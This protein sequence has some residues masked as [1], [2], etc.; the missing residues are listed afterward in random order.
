MEE[1][2]RIF[3]R[4]N[5]RIMFTSTRSIHPFTCIIAGPTGC[6]KTQFVSDMLFS[7]KI[8]EPPEKNYCVI[9]NGNLNIMIYIG[10]VIQNL[11]KGL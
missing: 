6:G 7:D 9:Q 11:L 5:F 3:K 4:Y 10:L 8:Y 1:I 2:I